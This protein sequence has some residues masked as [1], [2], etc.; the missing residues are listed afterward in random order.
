MWEKINS[1]VGSVQSI[2]FFHF[3]EKLSKN[4]FRYC[5]RHL[6]KEFQSLENLMSVLSYQLIWVTIMSS[7]TWARYLRLVKN[8]DRLHVQK[9]TFRTNQSSSSHGCLYRHQ[10]S[11]CTCGY[12]N[13][14]CSKYTWLYFAKVVQNG[15]FWSNEQNT[16][17]YTSFPKLYSN[18]LFTKNTWVSLVRFKQ[19]SNKTGFF[20]VPQHLHWET[21]SLIDSYVA[22]ICE[23]SSRWE[24]RVL[25]WVVPWI[26]SSR[27]LIEL[28]HRWYFSCRFRISLCGGACRPVGGQPPIQ[29]LFS[30]NICKTKTKEL[31]PVWGGGEGRQQHPLD[32]P[33]Y[34]AKYRRQREI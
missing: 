12:T 16:L 14:C 7:L 10:L 4:W 27:V 9:I 29:A 15:N 11:L 26:R 5:C 33:M 30:R 13:W 25:E 21:K 3:N 22:L 20:Q 2:R 19:I 17:E 23:V 32:P 1:S 31:S 6:S 18:V 28:R 8:S 34:L 24:R